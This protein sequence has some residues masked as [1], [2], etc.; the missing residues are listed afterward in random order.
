MKR[1]ANGVAFCLVFPCALTCW[2]ESALHR[3]GE[4]VFNFWTHVLALL[5]GHPGTYLR[6]AF[7]RLTL[8]SCH[9]TLAMGFGSFFSHREVHVEG[10]VYVGAFAVIGR[11]RLRTGCL[12]GTR[13]NLL[14][15]SMQHELDELGRWKPANL[16]NFREIEIGRHT[17]IG[18]AAT[19]MA[20]VGDGALVSA[21]A[22][23]AAPVA[24]GIVVAG[25]PAR[26]VRKVRP[27][28]AGGDGSSFKERG[29]EPIVHALH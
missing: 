28:A 16:A 13:A 15:G 6:R 8:A 11:A 9:P 14:S 12:I 2:I 27:E 17:W 22:V 7:Y 20:S 18:E 23:V 1:A 5:P 4:G 25:N 19:V 10:D 24:P 29:R 21:G 3:G 26:F